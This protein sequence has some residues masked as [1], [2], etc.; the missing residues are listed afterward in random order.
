MT[1]EQFCYW[2]QG[3]FELQGD[4]PQ[5]TPEQ[6]K[7]IGEHLATVFHK[8]T[9]TLQPATGSGVTITT[10]P[11]VQPTSPTVRETPEWIRRQAT[12]GQ[13]QGGIVAGGLSDLAWC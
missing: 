5:V 1:A 2:L 9:P 10:L 11:Y 3:F 8:V 4:A 7:M 12:C 6:A 13:A